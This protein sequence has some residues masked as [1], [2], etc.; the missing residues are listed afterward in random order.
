VI[1]YH[2]PK[3]IRHAMGKSSGKAAISQGLATIVERRQTR[4]RRPPGKY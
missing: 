4:G 3:I 2:L 1:Y